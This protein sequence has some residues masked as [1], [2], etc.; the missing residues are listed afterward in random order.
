MANPLIYTQSDFVAADGGMP[1]MEK[2]RTELEAGGFASTPVTFDGVNSQNGGAAIAVQVRFSGVPDATDEAECDAIIAAHTET[3]PAASPYSLDD[4]VLVFA[5]AEG[6]TTT[7]DSDSGV[8][9]IDF[10]ECSDQRVVMDENISSIT[11]SNGPAS[12]R[13]RIIRLTIVQAAGLYTLPATWSWVDRWLSDS[14]SAPAAPS[15]NG[16]EILITI[17]DN[18]SEVR[19]AAA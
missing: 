14:G 5:R 4:G 10:D 2:L 8:L 13:T 9:N 3:P 6:E 16:D 18:G 19:A 17:Y 7:L 1:H 12:G 15:G 11:R